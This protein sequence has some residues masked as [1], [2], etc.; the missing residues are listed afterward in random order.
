VVD[1]C[2]ISQL[3]L[4]FLR[5]L[6]GSKVQEKRE[7][8]FGRDEHQEIDHETV[9]SIHR[10]TRH[11]YVKLPLHRVGAIVSDTRAV[12]DVGCQSKEES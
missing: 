12:L 2:A 4:T 5:T 8:F 1:N 11:G 10:S 7:Y 3:G 9:D 6:Q